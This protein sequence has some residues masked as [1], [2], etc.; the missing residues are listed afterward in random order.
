MYASLSYN[1][2]ITLCPRSSIPLSAWNPISYVPPSPATAIT[3]IFLSSLIKPF[4]FSILIAVSTPEATDA[5]FSNATCIHGTF[6]AVYGYI[7]DAT[8]KHPVAFTII[9]FGPATFVKCLMIVPAR[10]PAH[11]LCPLTKYSSVGRSLK[12]LKYGFAVILS[13][14]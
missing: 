9:V 10:H 1:T 5:A 4:F 14:Q 11:N 13:P 2:Y 12:D 3:L 7:V 8:S 6:H